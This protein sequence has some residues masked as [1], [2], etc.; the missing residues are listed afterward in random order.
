MN[1]GDTFISVCGPV[2]DRARL[3]ADLAATATAHF[4]FTLSGILGNNDGFYLPQTIWAD[5]VHT[6]DRLTLSIGLAYEAECLW[7]GRVL[8]R[9]YPTLSFH[10][11]FS[12]EGEIPDLVAVGFCRGRRLYRSLL[13][14]PA[15][16]INDPDHIRT[17]FW[18]RT[19]KRAEVAPLARDVVGDR[20]LAVLAA[21]PPVAGTWRHL[22]EHRDHSLFYRPPIRERNGQAVRFTN[23][24]FS[25]LH[26]LDT[27]GGY[28]RQETLSAGDVINRHPELRDVVEKI[29]HLHFEER[30]RCEQACATFD[31]EIAF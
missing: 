15:F 18:I 31:E 2:A 1:C 12:A 21:E 3:R 11:T 23:G 7:L 10:G 28:A 22:D 4:A 19:F 5:L 9:R 16:V 17:G 8:S 25:I 24:E 13:H 6:G 29:C 30:E 14:E 20:G 27:R 26:Y